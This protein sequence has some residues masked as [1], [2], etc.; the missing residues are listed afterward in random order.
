MQTT[1][2]SAQKT[3]TT[4]TPTTQAK[5]SQSSRIVAIAGLALIFLFFSPFVSC[6]DATLS[7]SEA[8][9]ESL[10]MQADMN[11][12]DGYVAGLSLILFPV[13]GVIA[14]L[15]GVQALSDLSRG[16][17]ANRQS[18]FALLAALA[19]GWPI[20]EAIR[21]VERSDGIWHLEWGFYGSVLAAIGVLIGSLGL[22]SA[23]DKHP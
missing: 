22:R 7:G 4:A 10:S 12:D 16:K 5:A 9:Q 3:E 17:S 18:T 2:N 15:A 11:S 21:V 6:G 13:A 20:F 19:T 23:R 1:N 14:L 8:F